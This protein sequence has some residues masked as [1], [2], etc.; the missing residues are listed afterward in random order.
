M[1]TLAVL[2]AELQS[3]VP[4]V[5]S[6]PTVTQYTQAIKDAVA[7]FSRR[8]GLAKVATLSIVSGTATY[9]LPSDFLKMI[10]LESVSGADGVIISDSGIIPISADWDETYQIVNKVITFSPTPAY[11][12]TREYRYKMAWVLSGASESETYADMGED[13]AQIVMLKAKSLAKEKLANALASG[14]GMKYS[15]GAVSVDKGSGTETMTSDVYK[16]HGQFI[17]ACDRYNGAALW[18]S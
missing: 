12:M 1:T 13:E 10:M 15:L 4:A 6:V 11:S 7:E 2:I 14:G 8:C 5:N 9:N 3:E 16:L 18:I 17:E